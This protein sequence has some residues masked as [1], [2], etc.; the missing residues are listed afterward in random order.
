MSARLNLEP[1][2]DRE[3][4]GVLNPGDIFI[5]DLNAFGSQGGVI[6]VNSATG[7]QTTITSG[8]NL[9]PFAIAVTADEIYVTTTGTDAVIRIDPIT[10]S[11]TTVTSGGM[12]VAPRAIAVAANGDIFIADEDAFAGATGGVIR[13]DP[14][15]GARRP[16]R[17]ATCSATR[18]GLRSPQ[19]ESGFFFFFFFFFFLK[20]K[21]KKKKKYDP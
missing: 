18:E 3:V 14:M 5:A 20:K 11:G 1:L 4:P 2:E 13:V 17:R 7:G 9:R 10:G 19:G 15:T 21:K 12:L 6:Q 8:G 16:S